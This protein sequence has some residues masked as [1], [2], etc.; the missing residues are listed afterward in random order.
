MLQRFLKNQ[1]TFADAD[2]VANNFYALYIGKTGELPQPADSIYLAFD[3]GEYSID[4]DDPVEEHT[5]PVLRQ[6]LISHSV[7]Q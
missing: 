1:M 2:A 3:R 5:R 4:D 7:T 6:I